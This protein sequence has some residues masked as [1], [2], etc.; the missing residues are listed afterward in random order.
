MNQE[1]KNKLH[2]AILELLN[3][4]V[5]IC[6]E[7]NLT[8]FL[9]AGT[10]LG[11]VRHKGFIPWDDDIDVAMPRKDYEIFLDLYENVKETNYYVLSYRSHNRAG[12]FCKHFAKFCKKDTVFAESY[13][14]SD[15]YPGIFIDIF[16]FDNCVYFI[17]PIQTI[18]IKFFLNI[19]RLKNNTILTKK[20]IKLLI[21]KMF[22]FFFPLIFIEDMHK[23]LYLLFNEHKTR[24][25]SFFSGRYGYKRETHKYDI[26]FPLTKVL[27]EGKHYNAPNNWDSFLRTLYGSYMELPP[28]EERHT[29]SHEY[30]VF[31][32]GE[33]S[34][35]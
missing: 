15:G 35:E 20:K 21:A 3:E 10:L 6:E 26:I 30:I 33:M 5:S 8:Y 24:H 28:V 34:K 22:A 32:N 7:N 31:Y 27:F 11:A 1:T 2:S 29:H 4:F 14:T 25:I 23:N 18:L 17:A 16:P 9:T 19:Y 13:R 12:N